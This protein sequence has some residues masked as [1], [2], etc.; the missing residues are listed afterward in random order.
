MHSLLLFDVN[1]REIPVDALQRIFQS[2]TGFQRVR[3]NTPTGTPIE[4]DYIDGQDF[5]TVG[6]D[7]KRETISIRGTSG[8]AL[9]AA[10]ILQ[11]Y[12][13]IPLRMVD[14]EYSFDLI[15]SNFSNIE[16]LRTAIDNAQAS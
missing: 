16:E 12:L 8:A 14:T 4:A 3:H 1:D 10:W 15:L 9:S 13:D 5:T 11:R 2:I 6:L 7:S